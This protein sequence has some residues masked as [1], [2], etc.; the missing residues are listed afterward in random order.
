[1]TTLPEIHQFE[2]TQN[3]ILNQTQEHIINSTPLSLP[4]NDVIELSKTTTSEHALQSV[5]NYDDIGKT[6]QADSTP[7]T[8]EIKDVPTEG[9]KVKNVPVQTSRPKVHL[10]QKGLFHKNW[11]NLKNYHD[12]LFSSYHLKPAAEIPEYKN[13]LLRPKAE[14]PPSPNEVVS[15]HTPR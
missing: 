15:N 7:T 1:M 14:P 6:A 10:Q 13:R 5:E 4:N 12:I 3:K 11:R 9:D 8:L 2:K